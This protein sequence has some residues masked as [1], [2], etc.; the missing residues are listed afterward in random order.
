MT[1]LA[2]KAPPALR[3]ILMI[4]D[5]T[6]DGRGVVI[7]NDLL[8][9][10]AE[11]DRAQL[12]ECHRYPDRLLGDEA[13]P[14]ADLKGLLNRLAG[15]AWSAQFEIGADAKSARLYLEALRSALSRKIE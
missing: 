3:T 15:H 10:H 4:L 12:L 5:P 8:A 6:D 9:Q 13:T 11:I 7:P 2:H 1:T 14:N